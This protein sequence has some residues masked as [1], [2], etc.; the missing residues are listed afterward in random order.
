[1]LEGRRGKN[2]GKR[3]RIKSVEKKQRA[4]EKLRDEKATETDKV[5]AEMRY[6]NTGKKKKKWAWEY[7]N[8]LLK[9]E[10]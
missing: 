7:C 4:I 10:G 8:R 1:M 2:G 9:E 6:G 5:L 3:K